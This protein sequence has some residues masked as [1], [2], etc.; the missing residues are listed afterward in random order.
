M[1]EETVPVKHNKYIHALTLPSA[2]P[3]IRLL[4]MAGAVTALALALLAITWGGA[5]T[6]QGQ[7]NCDV[8][9]LGTLSADA[10]SEL[11]GTGRWT[12][13]DCNSRFRTGSDA[14]SFRFEVIEGGRIRIDLDSP[15]GDSFLYL[16][17]KDGRRLTD[18]DDGGA[19]IDARIERDLAPG[20]YIVEAT[21]VGGRSRG[22]ADFTLSISRATGCD[23]VNLG[24]LRTGINLT[25]SG[26]WSL[27]TCGSRF[28]VEHPAHSYL[29]TLNQAARV[30]VDLMSENGDPVLSLVSTTDGLI[31]ANDDG[32]EA[33]NSRINRYLAPGTYLLEATTYL[34]RDLQPLMADFTL[35][36]QLVDERADQATFLLKIE[37]VHTPD[38]VVA[39]QPFDV[40]YRVGNVGGGDLSDINGDARVYVVGPR[41]LFDITGR[42]GASEGNWASRVSYH[43]GSQTESETSVTH[44]EIAPFEATLGSPGPSWIFVGVVTDDEDGNERGFH[45]Q[46]HNLMVLSG[47]TF[48]EVT[49]RV[50]ETDYR[51]EANADEDG[52]VTTTV[53]SVDDPEA[54]VDPS[55]RAKAIYTAGVRTQVVEG[56]FERPAIA[57]LAVTGASTPTDV[58]NPSSTALLEKFAGRYTTAITLSGLPGV[59]AAKEALNPATIE[60]LVLRLSRSAS[61]EYVSLAASWS[62]LQDRIN[63]GETLSSEDAFALYSELAYAE[64]VI[65]PAVSAGRAVEAA[66]A[67]EL[68]WQDAGVQEMLDDLALQASCRD[69]GRGLREVLREMETTDLDDMLRLDAEMRAALPAYGFAKDAV[70]CAVTGVDRHNTLFLESLAIA[71]DSDI[72][73][74]LGY[75][76]PT[77]TTVAP[78]P[79]Q[80]RIIAMLDEEGRIEH[81]VELPNG[82]Q[83]LPS[84]RHLASDAP[85]GV[86]QI[87]SD[88]EVDGTPIGRV[89]SRRLDDGRVEFGFMDAV[90]EMIT[91]D[92]RYLSEDIPAGVW[93]RSAEIEVTREPTLE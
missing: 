9:D 72:L 4:T 7:S 68:G 22:P 65:S 79:Y 82:E 57:D 25:A 26:S 37:D 76:Q 77:A 24:T 47:T 29:F 93:L 49:V 28:V 35:V 51:V 69:P 5:T 39:G 6:A 89:R 64:R 53:S 73:E 91:P 34:E 60:D 32:G 71:D 2:G 66:R 44:G 63:E 42:I 15:D 88:V 84:R 8:T 30:R 55:L 46:W 1:E 80:L 54:D 43:T 18:N 92:I 62:A 23:P 59:L 45:G 14:H 70:L 10:D 19:G 33:R 61:I 40:H 67:A 87:S 36:V 12:T 81:G 58:E 31:A 85:S 16:L 52:M 48:D 38:Q 21:T 3:G 11:T 74:L 90:G 13:N 78:P 86:W 41:P 56:I 75:E 20:I 83:I 27:D 50:G 17:T